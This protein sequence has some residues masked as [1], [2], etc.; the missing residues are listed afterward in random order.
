MRQ[1]IGGAMTLKRGMTAPEPKFSHI[2]GYLTGSAGMK[3]HK[4][5]LPAER[6][7]GNKFT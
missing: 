3:D 2:Y 1:V 4:V 5:H 6:N 7:S